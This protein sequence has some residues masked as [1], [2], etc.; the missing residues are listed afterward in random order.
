VTCDDA[1]QVVTPWHIDVSRGRGVLEAPHAQL[2]AGDPGD[3]GEHGSR[4]QGLATQDSTVATTAR[5]RVVGM[6][7][8]CIAALTDDVLA[9]P[10][11]D[12]GEAGNMRM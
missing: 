1:S 9:Q 3:P 8:A 5:E 7:R 4:Q 2:A 12:R 10:G 11:T 6:P